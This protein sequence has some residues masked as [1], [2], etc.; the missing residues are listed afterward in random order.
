MSRVPG[1]ANSLFLPALGMGNRTS[2]EE[3]V[4]NPGGCARGG[5][6]T[7]IIEPCVINCRMD[8]F[9]DVTQ[10]CDFSCFSLKQK[11]VSMN[12]FTVPNLV[13]LWSFRKIRCKLLEIWEPKVANIYK[14]MYAKEQALAPFLCKYWQLYALIFPWV[15]NGFSWNFTG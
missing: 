9:D 2:I 1:V 8:H 14:E 10:N 3:K 7:T 5:M 13:N 12:R 4:A 11:F 15:C 6:I